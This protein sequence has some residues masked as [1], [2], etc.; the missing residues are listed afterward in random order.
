MKETGALMVRVYLAESDRALNRIL[1][2]LHDELQVSGV[3][4]TRGIE[5]YGDSGVVH[6]A[7]LVDLSADLPLVLEFFEEP[8]KARAAMARIAEYIAPGHMVSWPVTIEKGD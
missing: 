3:T 7:S 5:G 4:I 8:A 6:T 2:C 1:D